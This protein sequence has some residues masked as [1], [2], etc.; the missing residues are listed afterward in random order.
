MQAAFQA[1]PSIPV[2]IGIHMGDI[3]LS[4]VEIIGDS[5]NIASRIES[6]AA[7]GSVFLSE[8]VRDEI[9]NHPALELQSMGHVE[10]KNVDQPMEVFAVA[11][12]GL[13]VPDPDELSTKA[14]LSGVRPNP[15][16]RLRLMVLL[17]VIGLLLSTI[18]WLIWREPAQFGREKERSI[19]VLPFEDM[20]E[21]KDQAYFS[22]GIT[23]DIIAHLSKIADLRV[24]SRTS[25][26]QYKQTTKTIP[27]I[28]QELGV[29]TIL[30]GSVR[31]E[32]NALR[33]TAQLID[34]AT[35]EHIWAETYDRDLTKIFDIQREV[36]IEIATVLQ[37]AL[38]P[39]ETKQLDQP[40][41][42]DITAYDYY[43]RGKEVL[44]NGVTQ[45]D[46][47]QA[48]QLFQQAIAEDSGFA[49]A[50]V[51]LAY[52]AV[53]SRR[54]GSGEE[55]WRDSAWALN[56]K[57]LSLNPESDE[58]HFQQ[59][60]FYEL[61]G[62]KAKSRQGFEKVLKLNPNH[63]FAMMKLGNILIAE[64]DF[65][66]GLQLVIDG[67]LVQM[68]RKEPQ[69]YL[70]WGEV[71]QALGELEKARRYFEQAIKLKPD[72][73]QAYEKLCDL[74]VPERSYQELLEC[75]RNMVEIERN[76]FSL[77]RLAWAYLRLGNYELAKQ[78][79]EEL[80]EMQAGSGD[81][82]LAVPYKHRLAYIHWQTGR[83]EEA[84][85]LFEES[86][87]DNLALIEKGLET[88]SRG[89]YYDLAAIYAFLGQEEESLKWFR[90]AADSGFFAVDWMKYDPLIAGV[91]DDARYQAIIN[92]SGRT[93]GGENEESIARLDFARQRLRELEAKGILNL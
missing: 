86:I 64:G 57:A 66:K 10:F 76:P 49:A 45:Q 60:T 12:E 47:Q 32:G 65:E 52:T 87:R 78:A 77:D 81:P 88:Q 20:S 71:Y 34:A 25:T 80:G 85:T 2:R 23:E 31:K 38:S 91:L 17:V 42:E 56:A 84:Q 73:Y 4:G 63:G 50:Y 21:K 74:M 41:T 15:R 44:D 92:N 6:L 59:A 28:G 61:G 18:G 79:W 83:K 1:E 3:V 70:A 48:T 75:A 69:F 35:D 46:F 40:T 26:R 33:I 7:A 90:V 30:E 37:A 39:S 55:V 54:Y 19:A 22:D 53:I 11:N 43:L 24:I 8:K 93:L 5:V 16:T 51:G 9:R 13:V 27:E 36:A 29:T 14:K 58:A 89:E 67:L 62:Y 82:Y 72:Y 68:D